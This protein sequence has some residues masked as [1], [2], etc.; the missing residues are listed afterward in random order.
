MSMP[1]PEVEVETPF[2]TDGKVIAPWVDLNPKT[3]TADDCLRAIEF[4]FQGPHDH[5]HPLGH[6]GKVDVSEIP[7]LQHPGIDKNLPRS[8]LCL[9]TSEAHFM[10]IQQIVD[11]MNK[12]LGKHGPSQH[13]H[14][15]QQDA[16]WE[17]IFDFP[18]C[19]EAI[20]MIAHRHAQEK[21]PESKRQQQQERPHYYS[22]P[23]RD[24]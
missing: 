10:H 14:Y 7:E 20:N 9:Y 18:A 21:Q 1:L 2:E 16:A 19:A 8:C 4:L 22:R 23:T 24:F 6:V 17:V 5:N 3:A 15:F 12:S 11:L 13:S